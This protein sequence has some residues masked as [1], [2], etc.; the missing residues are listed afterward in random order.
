MKKIVKVSKKR[1]SPKNT[2]T[3]HRG[4]KHY[5][6]NKTI[7]SYYGTPIDPIGLIFLLNWV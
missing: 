6:L 3:R 4:P 2:H 5:V 1:F 7:E